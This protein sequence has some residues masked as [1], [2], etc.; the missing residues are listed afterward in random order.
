VMVGNVYAIPPGAAVH[1]VV[2]QAQSS[3]GEQRAVLVLRFTS[4]DVAGGP[5]GIAARLTAVDNARERVDEQGQIN[6]AFTQNCWKQ[7]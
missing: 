1:G 5:A 2:T 3:S 6:G 7:E 4:V